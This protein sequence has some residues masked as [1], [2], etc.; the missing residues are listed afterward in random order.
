MSLDGRSLQRAMP[1]LEHDL[2]NRYAP[3]L[4]EAMREGDITTQKRSAAW[5]AQLGHESV[6]LRYFEEI[7]SGAAYEGRTDLGNTQP[8]D[9]VRY[10]GR[11]PIQLTGRANYREAGKALD[12]PLEDRPQMASEPRVGF[13]VA[14]WY[15]TTRGLN[16]LADRGDFREITIR[17]N[18]G[19]NGYDDRCSRWSI[20][21]GL[22]DA[23]VPPPAE[24]AYTDRQ[25]G[26]LADLRVASRRV[27]AAVK[28]ERAKVEKANDERAK[29]LR[30]RA[31]RLRED[32]AEV[33][34]DLR[35]KSASKGDKRE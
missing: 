13:R 15:W 12:L 11:G 16:P 30:D 14:V 18:G 27:L 1:G 29:L 22:G 3:P 17:I 8:G 23:I 24:L 9:G 34:Q 6:S 21:K 33:G 25:R 7:A 19:L 35:P 28:R 2:A 32:A 4:I 31:Q 20:C 10:K 5:L 26:L